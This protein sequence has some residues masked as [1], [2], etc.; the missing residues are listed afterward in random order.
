ML[1]GNLPEFLLFLRDAA[2]A[3]MDRA[4]TRPQ[5]T[6]HPAMDITELVGPISLGLVTEPLP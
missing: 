3:D 5:G 4:G 2:H 6:Q 1:D